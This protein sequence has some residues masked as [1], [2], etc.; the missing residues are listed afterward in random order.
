MRA[1]CKE[2]MRLWREYNA[3]TESYYDLEARLRIAT[4]NRDWEQIGTLNHRYLGAGWRQTFLRA[5][6]A[7]HEQATHSAASGASA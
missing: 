6:I 2:C 3:A 4:E 7:Q 5:A 1:D